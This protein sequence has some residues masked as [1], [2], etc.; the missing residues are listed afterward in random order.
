[1]T[2]TITINTDSKTV[3]MTNDGDD[4]KTEDFILEEVPSILGAYY[5]RLAK[6]RVPDGVNPEEHGMMRLVANNSTIFP[7]MAILE[8]CN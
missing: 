5:G 6:S 2:I 1:M 4:R 3:T 7:Q 8:Y